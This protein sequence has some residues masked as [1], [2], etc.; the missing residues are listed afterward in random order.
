[1]EYPHLEY[2]RAYCPLAKEGGCDRYKEWLIEKDKDKLPQMLH[3]GKG[4]STPC[5]LDETITEGVY[6]WQEIFTFESCD[7]S[8]E[9]INTF[10]QN[11]LNEYIPTTF[12]LIDNKLTFEMVFTPKSAIIYFKMV[13]PHFKTLSMQGDVGVLMTNLKQYLST[14]SPAFK[15]T[16]LKYISEL[17]AQFEI[18]ELTGK[19]LDFIREKFPLWKHLG[20]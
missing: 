9:Q 13:C 2:I 1:M 18:T 12:K 3:I 19:Y 5:I 8:F 4:Y 11:K 10:L 14:K 20:E 17:I 16:A 6:V 15:M 7:L